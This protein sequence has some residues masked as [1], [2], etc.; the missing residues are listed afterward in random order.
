MYA[1]LPVKWDN[2]TELDLYHYIYLCYLMLV[3]V[4]ISKIMEE[5][6]TITLPL[7][8]SLTFFFIYIFLLF[9]FLTNLTKG[10]CGGGWVEYR[11]GWR[12][13]WGRW[14]MARSV[15]QSSFTFFTTTLLLSS[16]LV[17]LYCVS[18]SPETSLCQNS[19][20]YVNNN[21]LSPHFCSFIHQSTSI[22][23]SVWK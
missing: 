18:H 22:S 15:R 13:V 21:S 7:P 23:L 12:L 4:H 3:L 1:F 8:F 6:L 20:K 14:G 17:T 9:L 16:S 2:I 11:S 10:S 19:N 5:K